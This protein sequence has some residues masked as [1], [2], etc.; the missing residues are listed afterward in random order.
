MDEEMD[1]MIGDVSDDAADGVADDTID[2]EEA[3]EV[4]GDEMELEVGSVDAVSDDVTPDVDVTGTGGKSVAA[5]LSGSG[6][7]PVI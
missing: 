4:L 1:D 5:T 2:E 6:T 7:V 3:G